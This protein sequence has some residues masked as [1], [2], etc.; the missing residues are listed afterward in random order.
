MQKDVRD[1]FL[2]NHLTT[3]GN[4]N[5]LYENNSS[6]FISRMGVMLKE[7][8][9]RKKER[10][11]QDYDPILDLN[12]FIYTIEGFGLVTSYMGDI[13]EVYF[14]KTVDRIIEQYK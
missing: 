13:D 6:A 5:S 3:V 4:V 12:M 8:F 14:N 11:P 7:Y 1:Q 9:I 2:K 10:K